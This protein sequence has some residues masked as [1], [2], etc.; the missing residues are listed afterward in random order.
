MQD[1]IDIIERGFEHGGR[2]SDDNEQ[3]Q[4]T[5]AVQEAIAALHM[6]IEDLMGHSNQQSS[7]PRLNQR[8]I[9][10]AQWQNDLLTGLVRSSSGSI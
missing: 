8:L 1:L 7:D 10:Y 3:R 4:L 6:A 5:E 9:R 2:L